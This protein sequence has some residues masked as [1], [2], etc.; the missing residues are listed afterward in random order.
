MHLRIHTP[1]DEA[2]MKCRG[3]YAFLLGV[4]FALLAAINNGVIVSVDV[5]MWISSDYQPQ[6]VMV[7]PLD[8][9]TCQKFPGVVA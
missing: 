2:R 8:E 4:F 5:P 1:L 6:I 9:E 7:S 3:G